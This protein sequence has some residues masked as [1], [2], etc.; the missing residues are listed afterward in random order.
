M[1]C[2]SASGVTPSVNCEGVP[3]GAV[4]LAYLVKE[5]VLELFEGIG[6]FSPNCFRTVLNSATFKVF[7]AK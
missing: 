6:T 5:T 2:N 7:F 3:L 4:Y 1:V